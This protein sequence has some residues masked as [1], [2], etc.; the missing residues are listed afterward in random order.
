MHSSPTVRTLPRLSKGTCSLV[1]TSSL[2]CLLAHLLA[3]LFIIDVTIVRE[4]TVATHSGCWR[5]HALLA[6]ERTRDV[7]WKRASEVVAL[8]HRCVMDGYSG[9]RTNFI[10]SAI[11][12]GNHCILNENYSHC[13]HVQFIYLIINVLEMQIAIYQNTSNI[14]NPINCC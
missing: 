13:S 6:Q 3:Y 2:P 10:I 4:S 14:I 5:K 12:T 9:V 1:T 11:D 7:S 8:R